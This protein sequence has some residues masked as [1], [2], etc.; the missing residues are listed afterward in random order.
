MLLFC[1]GTSYC[2]RYILVQI[3]ARSSN[4]IRTLYPRQYSYHCYTALSCWSAW[5]NGWRPSHFSLLLLQLMPTRATAARAAADDATDKD[6]VMAG[7][8]QGATQTC[9]IPRLAVVVQFNSAS[10][11]SSSPITT[12]VLL[13]DLVGGF[14]SPQLG[15]WTG[16]SPP[17]GEVVNWGGG[18]K[19]WRSSLWSRV[20]YD[21]FPPAAMWQ[22]LPP[23]QLLL[24]PPWQL[25]WHSDRGGDRVVLRQDWEL[26][27]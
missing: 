26:W 6:S 21:W 23:W 2:S 14:S 25:L 8:E 16:F 22:L 18:G 24:P 19:G 27:W 9:G 10:S 17:G 11:Q 12:P 20:A 13:A 5:S 15:E 4:R 7:E 3:L 1:N